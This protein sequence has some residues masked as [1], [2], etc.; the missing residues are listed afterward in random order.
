LQKKLKLV[1]VNVIHL[2]AK[3]SKK[4]QD[5]PRVKTIFGLAHP[6]DGRTGSHPPQVTGPGAGPKN[7]KFWLNATPP[8]AAGA[9]ASPKKPAASAF[10]SNTYISVFDYF[11]RSKLYAERKKS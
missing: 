6:Q 11:K 8:A 4:G 2:P 3:K 7:V 5:I 9:K 10:P 1:R